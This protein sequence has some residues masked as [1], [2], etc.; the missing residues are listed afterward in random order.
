[1]SNND[2]LFQQLDEVFATILSGM[3]PT[4]RQRTAR[5]IGTTLRRSQSQR[6]GR[7]EAPD[8]SKYPQRKQRILRAQAG[9][10]F[11]WQGE[12][13][14]LRNWRAT[15]GRH[16]RMLTGF[17]ID[18]GDTAAVNLTHKAQTQFINIAAPFQDQLFDYTA[19][20]H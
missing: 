17:D 13:R 2:A 20:N 6:I 8:G 14:Q 11:I 1:M 5:S 18:R 4:G 7:Q 3:S 15:R 10:R 16:G 9:M 12:T 19:D